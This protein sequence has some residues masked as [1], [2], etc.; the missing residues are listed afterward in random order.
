[1]RYIKHLLI[2]AV[3]NCL[4]MLLVGLFFNS[5][6]F[7]AQF[8]VSSIFGLSISVVSFF[9]STFISWT[10]ITEGMFFGWVGLFLPVVYVAVLAYYSSRSQRVLCKA[11]WVN[12]V[13]L[14]LSACI[15]AHIIGSGVLYR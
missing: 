3:A 6:V 15:S 1:M 11:F 5:F 9:V 8:F 13:V 2:Y 7:D 10:I 4:I 14:I 12:A